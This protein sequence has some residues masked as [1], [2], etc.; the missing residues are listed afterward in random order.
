MIILSI[1]HIL[2]SQFWNMDLVHLNS[3]WKIHNQVLNTGPS[4]SVKASYCLCFDSIF[5][6]DFE[7]KN[8]PTL[9]STL[10][11][12][13]CNLDS[14]LGSMRVNSGFEDPLEKIDKVSFRKTK[15]HAHVDGGTF[16][17]FILLWKS[18]AKEGGENLYMSELEHGVTLAHKSFL[19]V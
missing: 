8:I 1:I 4:Q 13:Q 14:L 7:W 3:Y 15:H 18:W 2:S 11:T 10:C 17:V 19:Y 5:F 12:E 16:C 9:N 6:D